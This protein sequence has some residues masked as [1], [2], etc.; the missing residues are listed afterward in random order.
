MT[1]VVSVWRQTT[2]KR[3]WLFFDIAV[4]IGH[5]YRDESVELH[6]DCC[7]VVSIAP[8]MRRQSFSFERAPDIRHTATCLLLKQ[9]S[10]EA[11]V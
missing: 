11:A 10:E 5:V 6:V 8:R 1:C 7:L 2:W 9:A 4:C 3:P